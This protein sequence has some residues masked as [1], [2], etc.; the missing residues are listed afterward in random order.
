M[1]GHINGVLVCTTLFLLK[2]SMV[3][4]NLKLVRYIA[5]T[6]QNSD[7]I[8]GSPFGISIS[9]RLHKILGDQQDRWLFHTPL[10]I[11]FAN[12]LRQRRKIQITSSDK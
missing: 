3:G 2:I 5:R 4:V 10:E 6:F 8:F 9:V 7:F 1:I 12:T 11:K